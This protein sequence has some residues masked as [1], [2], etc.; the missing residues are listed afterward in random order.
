[1]IMFHHLITTTFEASRL[2]FGPDRSAEKLKPL[3]EAVETKISVGGCCFRPPIGPDNMGS[4]YCFG[5]KEFAVHPFAASDG[6]PQ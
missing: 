5:H 3:A 6:I 4:G 1:M 2:P